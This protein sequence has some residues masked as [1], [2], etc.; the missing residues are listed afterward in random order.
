[1]SPYL[2]HQLGRVGV[3]PQE[4]L[5][6][7]RFSF[8]WEQMEQL[9]RTPQFSFWR[10]AFARVWNK[11]WISSQKMRSI[12]WTQNAWKIDGQHVHLLKLE[13]SETCNAF[14]KKSFD[15]ERV[16]L[17]P[18]VKRKFQESNASTSLG[19]KM[20]K[21]SF[22]F[23]ARKTPTNGCAARHWNSVTSRVPIL[24]KHIRVCRSMCRSFCCPRGNMLS[25]LLQMWLDA[26]DFLLQR[27]QLLHFYPNV[28]GCNEMFHNFCWRQGIFSKKS[29]ARRNV[30]IINCIVSSRRGVWEAKRGE[31]RQKALPQHFGG[32]GLMFGAFWCNR[33]K[34][35][36]LQ[37]RKIWGLEL[38]VFMHL[39]WETERVDSSH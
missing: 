5:R 28:W 35:C 14:Q 23:N 3:H 15:Q 22:W 18:D 10:P 4:C 39:F 21:I 2:E 20:G 36:P 1:M 19:W 29:R 13:T 34:W 16:C 27:G 26:P 33:A 7:T 25:A 9:N 17:S 38:N 11:T 37:S 30:L 12:K 24:S 32:C 31:C 6:G 8:C